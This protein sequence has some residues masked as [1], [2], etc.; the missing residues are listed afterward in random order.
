MLGGFIFVFS[1]S[2][3]FR[4][5]FSAELLYSQRKLAGLAKPFGNARCAR[6]NVHRTGAHGDGGILG[7]KEEEKIP[8]RRVKV[9]ILTTVHHPFDRS[10]ERRVG[11]ECLA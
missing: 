6:H 1:S 10:E 3:N 7:E 4:L 9:C 8:A 11:K 2:A 5:T